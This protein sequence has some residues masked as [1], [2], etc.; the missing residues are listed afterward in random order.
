MQN[1]RREV[2]VTPRRARL[3]MARRSFR[4]VRA[5]RVPHAQDL[6]PRPRHAPGPARGAAAGPARPGSQ[7]A[8]LR[9]RLHLAEGVLNEDRAR[10]ACRVR[11]HQDV[12]LAALLARAAGLAA[13]LGRP[14][15]PRPDDAILAAAIP[16]LALLVAVQRGRLRL[17]AANVWEIFPAGGERPLAA[18]LSNTACG[19]ACTPVGPIQKCTRRR[20]A[21]QIQLRD[22]LPRRPKDNPDRRQHED[23]H[24]ASGRD[25]QVPQELCQRP[26]FG[27]LRL[28]VCNID[29]SARRMGVRVRRRSHRGPIMRAAL[30]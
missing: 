1:A 28:F 24:Q 11:P 10:R 26:I 8:H 25:A 15:A 9:A 4:Q 3:G 21:L 12:A 22:L 13:R 16:E 14:A 6:G 17:R 19:R 30:A 2:E 20:F 23:A 29:G 18:L 5:E 27:R 7:V